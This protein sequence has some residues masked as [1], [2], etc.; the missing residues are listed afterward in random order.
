[1]DITISVDELHA[2]Y[3]RIA[4]R[5]AALLQPMFHQLSQELT[6]MSGTVQ[7]DLD[8]L[9]AQLGTMNANLTAAV[10]AIQAEIAALQAAN[11]GVDTTALDA[12]VAAL[13]AEVD[14]VSAIA[15]PPSP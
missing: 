1:M 4:T 8:A 15:A 7:A 10:A 14:A 12:A 2:I 11:P 6:A 5:T 3:D 13:S 9:T